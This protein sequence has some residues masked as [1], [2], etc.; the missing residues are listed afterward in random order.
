MDNDS[1]QIKSSVSRISDTDSA[2]DSVSPSKRT[3][4]QL[5]SRSSKRARKP[6]GFYDQDKNLKEDESQKFKK[7]ESQIGSWKDVNICLSKLEQQKTNE[8]QFWDQSI[9]YDEEVKKIESNAFSIPPKLS[10]ITQK[11][12]DYL[13]AFSIIS[14]KIEC[15]Q[16]LQ[17][18]EAGMDSF[19]IQPRE[20]RK[21]ASKVKEA[22]FYLGK[23]GTMDIWL[24]FPRRTGSLSQKETLPDIIQLFL[25]NVIAYSL[26]LLQE[27]GKAVKRLIF[28]IED[29]RPKHNLMSIPSVS[30]CKQRKNDFLI[31]FI[32]VFNFYLEMNEE[33]KDWMDNHR[34]QIMAKEIG[35]DYI[36]LNDSNGPLE[37]FENCL[38]N[39]DLEF[40]AHME[41]A[42]AENVFLSCSSVAREGEPLSLLLP[43][44]S[45]KAF[46]NSEEK[47]L[48]TFQRYFS[49]DYCSFQ[50]AEAV[51]ATWTSK[52]Q[53][54]GISHISSQ[55]YYTDKSIL[56]ATKWEQPFFGGRF[57]KEALQPHPPTNATMN[58]LQKL[59]NV[60]DSFLSLQKRHIGLRCE[61]V[62]RISM[63]DENETEK[64]KCYNQIWLEKLVQTFSNC[65]II[66]SSQV[67]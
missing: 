44:S 23:Q 36:L 54:P 29:N 32:E 42:I 33:A 53:V 2:S 40:L 20:F 47:Q 14:N 60:Q 18:R 19:L 11:S 46:F 64:K 45:A 17:A 10:F 67:S 7:D 50:H 30:L 3:K 22:N 26:N 59:Y 25:Q 31:L 56:R 55:I 35:Q 62:A 34:C 48:R 37:Y 4:S 5:L 61:I 28:G 12:V 9:L 1:N 24:L 63:D 52:H 41:I 51:P 13:G 58:N 43:N 8:K 39:F 57:T 16:F 21:P 65:C 6:V 38:K 49:P 66:D 27:Q 15:I